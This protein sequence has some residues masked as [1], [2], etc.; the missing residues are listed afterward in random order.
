MSSND[1]ETFIK[2]PN[3]LVTIVVLAFVVPV[4]LI[5]FLSQL[6]TAGLKTAPSNPELTA[7]AVRARIAPVAQLKLAGSDGPKVLQSG[8]AV[9]K[10]VCMACHQ[11]GLLNAPKLG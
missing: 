2:T 8:E 11:T 1:H 9:Y 5:I 3:Q 4:L 6:V 10:A 7:D